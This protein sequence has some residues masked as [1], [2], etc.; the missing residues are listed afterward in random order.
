MY[1][2][3]ILDD[4]LFYYLFKNAIIFSKN[5]Y[6][7]LIIFFS[8]VSLCHCIT[9]YSIPFL[10]AKKCNVW[11][12]VEGRCC[13][14]LW[15]IYKFTVTVVQI[16]KQN[17]IALF[18]YWFLLSFNRYIDKINIHS[19]L[20]QLNFIFAINFFYKSSVTEALNSVSFN[21]FDFYQ[22]S[23]RCFSTMSWIN[24]ISFLFNLNI[25]LLLD[26]KKVK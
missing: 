14:S 16:R 5:F 4:W 17:L 13:P 21:F 11:R 7:T 2:V 10:S 6:Q 23:K 12:N 1:S 9:K 3:F 25:L 8:M 20:C 15:P 19:I 22:Q 24:F 18:F 26:K